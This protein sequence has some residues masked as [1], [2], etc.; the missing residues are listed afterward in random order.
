MKI[1]AKGR[2]VAEGI[3]KSIEEQGFRLKS[4]EIYRRL[5]LDEVK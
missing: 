4:I 2:E 1:R 5:N 3:I